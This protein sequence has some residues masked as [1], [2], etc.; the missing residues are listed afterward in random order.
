MYAYPKR[1]LVEYRSWRHPRTAQFLPQ[2]EH[3][4]A[5]PGLWQV[6]V[7]RRPDRL[8]VARVLSQRM[9]RARGLVGQNITGQVSGQIAPTGPQFIERWIA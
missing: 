4:R 9:A 2:I 3:G 6:P 5:R 7:S 8:A 1:R